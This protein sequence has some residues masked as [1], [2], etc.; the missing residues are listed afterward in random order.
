MTTA[1]DVPGVTCS[2]VS[3]LSEQVAMTVQTHL[4][5]L[6]ALPDSRIWLAFS[7]G[8]DST[9]LLHCL[10]QH[11]GLQARLT[12]LHVHH[13]LSPNA[14]AWQQHCAQQAQQYRVPLV[15]HAV[16][17]ISSGLGLE[18]AARQARYD[19]F[20]QSVGEQDVLLTAHHADDQIETFLQRWLRGAG[21]QGLGAMRAQRAL[22]QDSRL[23]P[24]SR[25]S[26]SLVRPLLSHTRTELEAYAKQQ[27]LV[28]IHDES[29]DDPRW[30]RN[31]WRNELLPTIWARFPRQKK[32]ALRA[33]EQLQQDQQLLSYLL[34]PY[35]ERTLRPTHWPNTA[36]WSLDLKALFALDDLLQPYVLRAWWQRLQLPPLSQQ[37]LRQWLQQLQA[38]PDRQ[39][40]WPLAGGVLQRHQQHCYWYRPVSL[41]PER[42]SLSTQSSFTWAGGVVACDSSSPCLVGDYA[43]IAA[44]SSAERSLQPAQRPRKTFKQLF[45]EHQV[46]PWLRSAWPVIVDQQGRV[47]TLVG[48]AVRDDGP[49][50]EPLS[51]QWRWSPEEHID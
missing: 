12:L 2:E 40:S 26:P 28:W 25:P 37:G 3:S 15:C 27:Q 8:L 21:L 16:S 45:Q 47:V 46:P 19:V 10:C 7:G 41:L 31:W 24:S 35:L 49:Q 22:S 18:A 36:P 39:P 42:M 9:V 33:I 34:E 4:T 44:E 5:A 20:R 29:N 1:H 13:G 50:Q 11:P 6:K 23:L 17:V 38:N 48:L 51:C 32:T 14:D 30:S 43:V